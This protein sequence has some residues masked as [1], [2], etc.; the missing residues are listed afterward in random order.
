MSLLLK[1]LLSLFIAKI[2][3]E[4]VETEE[5]SEE[6]V[7]EEE[8]EESNEDDPAEEQEE[9]QE[10]PR[11][12]RVSAFAKLRN[13]KAET[14]R[15]YQQALEELNATRRQSTQPTVNPDEQR[16]MELRKQEDSVLQNPNADEWQKYAVQSARDA[17]IAQLASQRALR[18]AQ[19]LSDKADFSQ[20]AM[21]H[22]AKAYEKYKSRVEDELKVMRSRGQN[23]PRRQI[24]A[25]LLGKDL[26]E[27][28]VKSTA[29]SKEENKPAKRAS[30]PGARSDVSSSGSG[31]MTEAEKR[32]KRL[33]NVRI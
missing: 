20:I 27:G 21:T 5:T 33:E 30:T 3:D 19:D 10:E 17:R 26:L 11:D 6:E 22:Q 29:K 23:A 15:K 31:R 4:P 2:D 25:F 7:T 8:T 32:A 1:K 28:N 9:I 14:E 12:K 18:E 24:M 16:E 13:E